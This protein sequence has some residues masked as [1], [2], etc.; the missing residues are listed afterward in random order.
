[1]A[2]IIEIH[3]GRLAWGRGGHG[4]RAGLGGI[5]GAVGWAVA[6]GRQILRGNGRGRDGSGLALGCGLSSKSQ[7]DL[8]AGVPARHIAKDGQSLAGRVDG[9]GDNVCKNESSLRMLADGG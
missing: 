8:G 1:M 6:T 4:L 7:L 2:E 5:T 9:R 3:K